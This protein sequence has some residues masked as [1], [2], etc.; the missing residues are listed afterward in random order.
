MPHGITRSGIEDLGEG[1]GSSAVRDMILLG[2]YERAEPAQTPF[3]FPEMELTQGPEH[4]LVSKHEASLSLG[5]CSEVSVDVAMK[6]KSQSFWLSTE[7]CF[8]PFRKNRFSIGQQALYFYSPF[9]PLY[10]CIFTPNRDRQVS[11]HL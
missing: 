6:S 4:S 8:C 3:L 1:E 10:P 11:C 2:L 7:N 9:I 5:R